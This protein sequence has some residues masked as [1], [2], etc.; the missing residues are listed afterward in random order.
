VEFVI[1]FSKHIELLSKTEIGKN[2]MN[3]KA[4]ESNA[5]L[6]T[7]LSGLNFMQICPTAYQAILVLLRENTMRICN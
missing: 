4:E 1:R 7:L 3:P 2:I 6:Y 5:G